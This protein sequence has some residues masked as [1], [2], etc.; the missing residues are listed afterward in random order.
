ME[1]KQTNSSIQEKK[2]ETASKEKNINTIN[3]INDNKNNVPA[4]KKLS[5]FWAGPHF[6]F[7]N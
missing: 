4:A 6:L 7:Y 3:V 1:R 2:I 5:H